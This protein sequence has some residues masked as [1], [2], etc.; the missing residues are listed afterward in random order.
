MG[1]R[2]IESSELNSRGFFLPQLGLKLPGVTAAERKRRLE[3]AAELAF[4]IAMND[5]LPSSTAAS[6]ARPPYLVRLSAAP[7]SESAPAVASKP[8]PFKKPVR[9]IFQVVKPPLFEAKLP[10]SRPI[11]GSSRAAA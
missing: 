7:A 10:I 9:R 5:Y 4:M 6:P 8:G 1:T 11:F 2:T 3:A